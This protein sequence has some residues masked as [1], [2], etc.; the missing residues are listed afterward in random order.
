MAFIYEDRVR[1]SSAFTGTGNVTLD[2]APDATFRT[3]GSQMANGDT[4]DIAIFGAGGFETCVATYNSSADELVRGTIYESSNAGARV[5]FGVGDKTIIMTLPAAKARALGQDKLVRG[6]QSQSLSSGEKLQAQSNMGALAVHALQSLNDNEKLQA[7]D[8][9]GL[10]GDNL[11]VNP[12]FQV[13][14]IN[15]GVGATTADNGYFADV[16]RLITEAASSTCYALDTTLGAGR[17]NGAISFTGTADKGGVFQA[18]ESTKTQRLRNKTV[19]LSAVLAVSN[20]RLGN[21]KMGIAQFTGTADATT[22]DPISAWNVDGTTPTLVANWSF[23]TTPA[24]LN[25]TTT[26][27]K[28]TV[29]G[30]VGASTNNLAIIIWNDDKAY[31]AGDL[32]YFTDIDLREGAGGPYRP[33]DPADDMSRVV[34]YAERL[35]S[36]WSSS[37][38]TTLGIGSSNWAPKRANPTLAL[39]AAGNLQGNGT[40]VVVTSIAS[41]ST[42]PTGGFWDFN[43][44]SG[45]SPGEGRT[46]RNGVIAVLARL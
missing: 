20:T 12:E 10:L 7:Q 14:Q 45:L 19:T 13:D 40:A 2:G 39:I 15:N 22:A 23:V 17:K 4:T 44:A 8:N 37:Y 6:D 42:T 1:E 11:V 16:Y 18:I 35:T 41:A 46:W 24:N 27:T 32:L 3:F 5:N 9:A 21:I 26:P 36:A 31:N 38:N 25:V 34:R 33:M 43:V 28:F 29:S 30:T